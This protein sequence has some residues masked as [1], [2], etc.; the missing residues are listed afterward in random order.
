MG[1]SFQ[2]PSLH[3]VDKRRAPSDHLRGDSK[4]ASG[5]ILGFIRT[6]V[7]IPGQLNSERQASTQKSL[8]YMAGALCDR[9]LISATILESVHEGPDAFRF[10][11]TGDR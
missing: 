5:C 10:G 4:S 11:R 8:S 2:V 3:D 7:L 6:V 9:V 1:H